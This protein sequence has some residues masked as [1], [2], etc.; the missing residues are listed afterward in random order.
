MA[1]ESEIGHLKKEL[2][3]SRALREHYEILEARI[4]LLEEIFPKLAGK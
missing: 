3:A 4:V 2:N 1:L